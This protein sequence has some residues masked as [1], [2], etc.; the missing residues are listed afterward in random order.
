VLE[1]DPSV[2]LTRES[3]DELL[4]WSEGITA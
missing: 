4:S 3:V 1:V 2:G